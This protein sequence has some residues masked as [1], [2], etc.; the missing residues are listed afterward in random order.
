MTPPQFVA[1]QRRLDLLLQQQPQPALEQTKTNQDLQQ[2]WHQVF[3]Q[4]NH[5]L[6]WFLMENETEKEVLVNPFLFDEDIQ[7]LLK[8]LFVNKKEH[9]TSQDP[10]T[11]SSISRYFLDRKKV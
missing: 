11:V 4:V 3:H 5:D 1:G 2:V 8:N 10:E 6:S 7:E 9:P